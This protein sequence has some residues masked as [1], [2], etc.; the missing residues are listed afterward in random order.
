MDPVIV[1][2]HKVAF[3]LGNW[4][5]SIIRQI[6]ETPPRTVASRESLGRVVSRLMT[7]FDAEINAN[8]TG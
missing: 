5:A 7:E 4:L 6:D 8:R 3:A 1:M 2:K